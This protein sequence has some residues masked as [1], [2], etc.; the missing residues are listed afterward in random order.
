MKSIDIRSESAVKLI[1][2]FLDLV[3]QDEPHSS[4]RNAEHFVHGAF[5]CPFCTRV[6][7]GCL[8]SEVYSYMRSPYKD[9]FVYD[10]V[11]QACLRLF[12]VMQA[13]AN[14]IFLF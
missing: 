3:D 11:V 9:L 1:S 13:N 8:S 6:T 2:E 12:V 4:R 5:S 14:L 10:S 7:D